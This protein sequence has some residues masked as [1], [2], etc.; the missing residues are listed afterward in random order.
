MYSGLNFIRSSLV[1]LT[2]PLVM[3]AAIPILLFTGSR[4]K[5]INYCTGLW[6]DLTSALIRMK[7][8]VNGA[9]HLQHPRPAVFILNHQSNADGFL[10]A[11][12]IRRDI[13]YLGKAELTKQ[14]IRSRI[15]QFGGLILVD[16]NNP[17]AASNAMQ[18]LINAIRKEG[19]SAAIFPEGRRSHS[20]T[21]RQFKKGAFLIALRA[22]VPIVPIVIHNSIDAQPRG[23][24][25]YHP[26]T[27][28]VDVLPPIDTSTWKVGALDQHMA[29]VRGLFL[30]ALGQ[31]N[32]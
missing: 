8:Q 30:D 5:A 19:L 13:A 2:M 25:I 23:E 11:K 3:I 24:S 17:A 29:D 26:A 4:R 1:P 28:K 21:L 9:E 22:K 27:V 18:A 14:P 12:L 16:R 20:T 31:Q 7:V 15:M 32:A 10:V 6:A